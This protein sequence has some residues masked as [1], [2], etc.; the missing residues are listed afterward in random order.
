MIVPGDFVEV[1]E[2]GLEIGSELDDR[3]FFMSIKHE[4][5]F[6]ESSI[7]EVPFVGDLGYF[8]D[9]FLFFEVHVALLNIIKY[10]YKLNQN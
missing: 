1:L 3:V 2:R 10:T 5:K 9:N 7:V 4:L 6:A 8:G